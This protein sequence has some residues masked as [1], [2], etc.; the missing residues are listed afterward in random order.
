MTTLL[1]QSKKGRSELV[2]QINEGL[3]QVKADGT[4]DKIYAKWFGSTKKYHQCECN[5]TII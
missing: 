5:I 1:L 2:N 3:K 4:Y